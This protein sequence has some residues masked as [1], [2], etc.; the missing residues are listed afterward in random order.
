[1]SE[2]HLNE[3]EQI[4]F[5]GKSNDAFLSLPISKVNHVAK[6]IKTTTTKEVK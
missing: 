1:M 5:C 3:S 4:R 6:K 2:T